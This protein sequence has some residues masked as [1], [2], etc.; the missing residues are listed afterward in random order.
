MLENQLFVLQ[1]TYGGKSGFYKKNAIFP[2]LLE[3][4]LKNIGSLLKNET[5]F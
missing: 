5:E 4:G 3:S 1:I 2:V